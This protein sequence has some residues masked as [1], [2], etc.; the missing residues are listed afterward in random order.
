MSDDREEMRARLLARRERDGDGEKD[1]F[2]DGS[3][4][5]LLLNVTFTVG[6]FIPYDMPS[7]PTF[8]NLYGEALDELAKAVAGVVRK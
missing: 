5:H 4:V 1:G 2:E 3:T 6:P 8:P 7:L